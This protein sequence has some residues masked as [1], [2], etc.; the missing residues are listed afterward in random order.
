MNIIQVY[1]NFEFIKNNKYILQ[2]D[3][4]FKNIINI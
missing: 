2:C 4:D 1:L 3:I